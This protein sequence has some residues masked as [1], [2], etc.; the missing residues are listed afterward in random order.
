MNTPQSRHSITDW[1]HA[2]NVAFATFVVTPEFVLTSS[3]QKDIV[4]MPISTESATVYK[5][6]FG[7]FAA[8]MIENRLRMSSVSAADLQRFVE[9][10]T[11]GKRDLNSKIAYRYLRLLERCY[12]WL[13]RS[14][15][16]AR[17]AIA[18]T[19]RAHIA[20]DAP[21]AA[22]NGDELERF[23]AALPAGRA[24]DQKGSAGW[25]RRRDRAM[26]VVMALAG[27]RVAEAVG[28]L[29]EEI[30]R[31][32][33]VEGAIELNITPEHKHATSYEHTAR[34]PREG[35]A[36]LQ[37]WLRERAEL[38]IPG[39][40]VFPAS[41]EGDALHKATVYRQVRATFERAG[42]AVPRAGGRTL[43]NTFAARQWQ[44]GATADEMTAVLGL[45][46]ERSAQ[47]YKY[48]RANPEDGV[49]PDAD[50][51]DELDDILGVKKPD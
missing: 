29:A 38:R 34:L 5:F 44:Q 24:P 11:D 31:Q 46:L 28:L 12:D 21:M 17:D 7:K 47:A 40:L 33:D 15:N 3:R 1:D 2:P 37:A 9:I 19:D 20:K 41:L 4:P 50:P 10:S 26:Q 16:P 39:E 32:A 8:W 23:L 42:V 45:A 49:D 27:L 25:K 22:L 6:M 18:A 51:D 36:E 14:P 35:V 43:R 30:G 13:E 48:A